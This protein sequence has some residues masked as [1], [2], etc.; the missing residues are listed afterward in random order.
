MLDLSPDLAVVTIDLEFRITFCSPVAQR[1]FGHLAAA[2]VGRKVTDIHDDLAVHNRRFLQAAA[3]VADGGSHLFEQQ[4][5]LD[6]GPHFLE[7]RMEGLFDRGVLVGYVLFSRDRTAQLRAQTRER[8]LARTIAHSPAAI[9]VTDAS[10]CIEFVNQRFS[11]NTGYSAEETVGQRPSL[12]ASGQTPRAV[13][14]AM[15][16]TILA[17]E[18]WSGELLNRHKSGELRWHDV[19][20]MPIVGPHQRVEYFVSIQEDVTDRKRGEETLRLSAKVFADSGEAIM[21]TDAGNRIVSVNRAFTDITGFTA[22]EV[23]GQNP[24]LLASGRHDAVFFAEMWRVLNESGRW[25]GEIWDRRKNGEI[26][27]KWLGIS[28]VRDTEGRLTHYLAVFSDITKRKAAEERISFLAYHDPLTG[29]PNRLLLRDRFEQAMGFAARADAG[30]ALLFLDLDRFKA[31]ND[32][33]GHTAGDALLQAVARRLQDCVRQTDT[34]SRLGGD[35]FAIILPDLRGSEVAAEV[36]RKI[37][38]RLAEPFTIDGQAVVTSCSIGIAL[39]PSDGEDFDTLVKKADTAM[40]CAKDAGRNAYRFFDASM[41]VGV[42]ETL[43][44]HTCLAEGVRKGEFALHYQPQVDIRTGRVSGCEALLRWNSARLGPMLPG[45]F[46]PAAEETGLIVP[47]GS[48]VLREACRQ[49]A[50]WRAAGLPETVVAVNL[51]TIQFR[52]GNLVEAVAGALAE[53]GLP[54]RCL[55]LELTESILADNI[56]TV[57]DTVRQLKELG[58]SLAIDDFG[59]G[60]SSLAYLKRFAVDRLKIDRSF[61]KDIL[62]DPEDAAIVRA[63]I[64]MARSLKLDIIA[65]GVEESRQAGYLVAEGCHAAQGYLF[66]RP[67]PAADFAALLLARGAVALPAKPL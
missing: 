41:N 6:D 22:D 31:V 25:Q 40:Y 32:T 16:K 27:P 38:D 59:T 2:V 60:Y 30:V 9:I 21:I 24:R 19:R 17:G 64:Q 12:I 39:Y 48:W 26:Y 45:A 63:V 36:A 54:A 56:D 33:L 23:L 62:A 34:I 53:S 8:L 52:R 10:G 3:R 15:W 58:V 51:S 20:I 11:E 7:S 4:V 29:L 46:V 28:A 55:E 35:E 5:E 67:M 44:L 57:L 43:V 14:E 49:A 65:E 50:A 47:I 18:E 37:L 66:G 61:I 42:A 1:L 13:Y